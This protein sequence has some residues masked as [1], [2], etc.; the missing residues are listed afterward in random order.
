[1]EM[2]LTEQNI[3][4]LVRANT[5]FASLADMANAA[6]DYFPTLTGEGEKQIVADAYD[7]MMAARGDGRR[8][9]RGTAKPA[10]LVSLVRAA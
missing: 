9:W 4:T 10:P 3:D 1:M 7:A 2:R 6:P 5:A 8:A